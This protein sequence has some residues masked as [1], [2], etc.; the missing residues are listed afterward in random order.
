MKTIVLFS[1][2]LDS[3]TALALAVAEHGADNVTALSVFYGQRHDKELCA[4]KKIADYYKVRQK[5]IDLLPLFRYSDC[6][7]LCGSSEEI[8]K[9]SYAEQ[10]KEASGNPVSTYVPF[11]NGLFISAAASIGLSLGC[12]RIYYA[13][14]RDDAAG[15]AYPDCSEKFHSFMKN[16]VETGTGGKIFL[17]APFVTWTKAQIVRYGLNMHVPYE[18]TWS[19]YAGDGKPCGVCGTCRD[20]IKAFELNGVKDPLKY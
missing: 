4:A 9:K 15:N 14:H 19:C 20:R 13:I 6:S 16:A 12:E 10:L 2:G 1:G 8:P 18:L 17:F 3:T 5:L 7:L 11:R